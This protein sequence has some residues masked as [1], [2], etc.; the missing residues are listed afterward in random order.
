MKTETNELMADFMGLEPYEDSRY[1][2]LWSSPIENE[3][4]CNF[5]LKFDTS[6]GWLMT[7]VEKIESIEDDHHGR[8]GVYINSNG[9][10]IQATKLRLDKP[11]TNPPMYYGERVLD[12]KLNATYQA[13][14]DFIK[15]Y[16]KR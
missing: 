11:M 14:V 4:G 10:V 3:T 8:F 12:T 16:N 7:V 6:W 1:G 13:V 2:I 15:W 5:V 9:C